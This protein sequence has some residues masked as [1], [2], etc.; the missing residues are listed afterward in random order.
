[1]AFEPR[2]PAAESV[3]GWRI[4]SCPGTVWAGWFLSGLTVLLLSV[5]AFG[6]LAQLDPVVQG[7]ARLGYPTH[8]VLA[9][10]VIELVSVAAYATPSTAVFGAILLTGY[11]GGG[12][13]SHVRIQDPVLTHAL[14][15]VFMGVLAWGG[16]W[17]REPRLRS[18]VPL[19]TVAG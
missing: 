19:R 3:A 6:K 18:L 7:T 17:L 14:A 9:I 4:A 10:G 1:V 11:L 2:G 5:D 16:L 13:A 8:L 12:V 15:P